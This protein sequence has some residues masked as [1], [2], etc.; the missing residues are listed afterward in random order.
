MPQAAAFTVLRSP[1]PLQEKAQ[2]PASVP[3]DILVAEDNEVN[4]LVFGQ[5]LAG[6]DLSYKI[7][8]NGR[9]AVEM[10][11]A[12]K[13][14]L[15]LMDVSMPEMNGYE[16]ARAIREAEAASGMHT[17][18]IGVTAMPAAACCSAGSAVIGVRLI[19]VAVLAR[20]IWGDRH[21]LLLAVEVAI[22]FD[23][24]ADSGCTPSPLS[25]RTG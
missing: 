12:F 9:T 6:L 17:P 15:I 18:I 24:A 11:R 7:A 13:P 22:G 25:A 8:A 3:L 14:R 2:Q 4:Q 16:A 10:Y 19:G 5:I 1:A 21:R 20:A 23:G